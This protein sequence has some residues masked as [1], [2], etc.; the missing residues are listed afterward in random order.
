MANISPAPI[1]KMQ[2]PAPYA[3]AA[4]PASGESTTMQM[5]YIMLSTLVKVARLALG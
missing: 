4:P 5:L 1:R 2:G 3:L